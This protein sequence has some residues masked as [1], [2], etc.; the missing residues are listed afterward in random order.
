MTPKV[1]INTALSSQIITHTLALR[2]SQ[3]NLWEDCEDVALAHKARIIEADRM[4]FE[5]GAGQV[6]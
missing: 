5:Q 3:S 2:Q 6:N 4:E 1:P